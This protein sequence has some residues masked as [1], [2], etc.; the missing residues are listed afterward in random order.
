MLAFTG[1]AQDEDLIKGVDLYQDGKFGQA[2]EVLQKFLVTDPNHWAAWTYL[3]GSLANLGRE[4]E[5]TAALRTKTQGRRDFKIVFEKE[6]K[7]TRNPKAVYTREARKNRVEGDLTLSV[8]F[9]ADGTIGFVI[10]ITTLPH[11]LTE[12]AIVAARKISFQP[13]RRKNKPVSVIRRVVY[14]FS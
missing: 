2:V 4:P 7:L 8:E 10:P 13:A 5:A 12:T 1:V 14:V 6:L 11:G 3:G 9:K